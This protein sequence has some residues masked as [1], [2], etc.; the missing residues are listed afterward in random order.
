MTNREFLTLFHGMFLGFLFL[1]AFAGGLAS[2]YSLRPGLVAASGLKPRLLRLKV[3][4]WLMTIVAW[5]LVITGT[6]VIYPWYRAPAPEGADLSLYPRSFLRAS[7]TLSSL[8]TFGMEWK[9]HIAWFAP[10]LATVVAYLV[11]RYGPE[12]AKK[13]QLR[14]IV[15]VLFVISFAAAGIAGVLGGLITQAAPIR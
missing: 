14:R 2:L 4:T 15:I 10:I 6:Y 7:E 9:E 3:S 12:L 11:M 13:S 8:H 5:L 1:L